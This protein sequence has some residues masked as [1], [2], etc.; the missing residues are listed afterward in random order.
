MV[1]DDSFVNTDFFRLKKIISMIEGFSDKIQFLI[2]TWNRESYLKFKDIF[3][4]HFIDL[5][6]KILP[7]SA[8]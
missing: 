8:A 4:A 3:N 6:E 2:F 5:E 7:F 1:L